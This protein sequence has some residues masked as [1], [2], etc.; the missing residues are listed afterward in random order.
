VATWCQTVQSGS[1][2]E[3]TDDDPPDFLSLRWL[4]M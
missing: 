4:R 2:A 3:N 1:L